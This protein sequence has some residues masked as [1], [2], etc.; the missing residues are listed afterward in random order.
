MNPH[1]I[2]DKEILTY[3][4]REINEGRLNGF[5][6]ADAERESHGNGELMEALNILK[7][8]EMLKKHGIARRVIRND[9]HPRDERITRKKYTAKLV[10]YRSNAGA[11]HSRLKKENS[12][13]LVTSFLGNFILLL[14]SVSAITAFLI[15][16]GN[17]VYDLSYWAIFGLAIGFM[18]L[19]CL[20][21]SLSTS[22]W[23]M[24]YQ[25]S[26][27]VTCIIMCMGSVMTGV[28]VMCQNP[29]NYVVEQ[30]DSEVDPQHQDGEGMRVNL[31]LVDSN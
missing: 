20:I 27:K 19:P 1:K 13:R 4:D 18:M 31:G 6:Q 23:R 17:T 25:T 26:L 11:A 12:R 10:R 21:S 2:Y 16:Q 3:I 14:G 8:L 24:P 30:M 29:Q 28:F 5:C 15:L 9:S 7:R 22:R